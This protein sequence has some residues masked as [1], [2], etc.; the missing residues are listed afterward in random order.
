MSDIGTIKKLMAGYMKRSDVADFTI[1]SVDTSLVALNSARKY[2]ERMHNFVHSQGF[3]TLAIA[4]TGT[5]I[6]ATIKTIQHVGLPVAGSEYM[7]C[8]FL[9]DQ[10]WTDRLRRLMGRTAYTPASTLTQLGF[11]NTNPV[12]YQQGTKLYL[13]PAPQFS[14]PVTVQLDVVNWLSDY[15]ADGNTDFITNNAPDFLMWQGILELNKYWKQ[16]SERTEGNVKE[17]EVAQFRDA[18]LASLIQWDQSL[19]MGTSTPAPRQRTVQEPAK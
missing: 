4:S 8:E 11:S 16:F 7:P 18:A 14:F 13:A 1:N 3:A 5:T 6:T 17:E 10:E 9:T 15:T 12:A 2:A 19:M